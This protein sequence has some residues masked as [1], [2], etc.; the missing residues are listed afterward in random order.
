MQ[1]KKK[2]K[3][4]RKEKLS[5]E[6]ERQINPLYLF[7]VKRRRNNNNMQTDINSLTTNVPIIQKPVS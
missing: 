1:K 4:K 7:R 3:K 5:K 2:R 6:Y